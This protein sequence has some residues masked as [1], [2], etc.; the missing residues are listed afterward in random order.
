MIHIFYIFILFPLVWEI[1]VT[2]SPRKVSNFV[3]EF[4]G[5]SMDE[6]TPKQKQ[7]GY[8]MLGYLI[9]NLLGL[10]TGQ[11]ILF[12]I[13]LGLG[14]IPKNNVFLTFLNGFISLVILIFLVIN[15]YHLH[16]DLY[17]VL[18]K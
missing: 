8:Y 1:I 12:T 5:L 14:L 10:L 4:K 11:W 7:L 6:A 15:Q 13:I 3:R 9:W 2:S 18:F 17:S 16:I